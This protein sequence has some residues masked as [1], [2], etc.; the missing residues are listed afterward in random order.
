MGDD[1]SPKVDLLGDPWTP[2]RDPRGRKRHKRNPLVAENVAILRASGATVEEIALRTGLS[3]PT[4]RQYY[5]RELDTTRAQALGRA[6]LR[7]AMWGKAKKGVVSAAR[8]ILEEFERG[9]AA[10]PLA[11]AP[12]AATPEADEKL[13]KKA[14]ANLAAETAHEGTEWGHLLKH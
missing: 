6:V 10:V 4:L 7:E 5:F 12:P 13:G 2:P 8:F 11:K 14:A 1:V 9:Q 3:E